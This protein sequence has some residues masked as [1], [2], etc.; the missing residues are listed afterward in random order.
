MRVR[1]LMHMDGC[2]DRTQ[3]HKTMHHIKAMTCVWPNYNRNFKRR[4]ERT[5]LLAKMKSYGMSA[6]SSTVMIDKVPPAT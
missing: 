2:R 3:G 1:V 6:S 4:V 5:N